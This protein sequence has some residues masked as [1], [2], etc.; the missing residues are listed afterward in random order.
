M[1]GPANSPYEGGKFEIKITLPDNYP[2]AVFSYG[3]AVIVGVSQRFKGLSS[4]YKR[5]R[6]K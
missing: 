4:D 5:N 6:R 1:N 2:H 3:N